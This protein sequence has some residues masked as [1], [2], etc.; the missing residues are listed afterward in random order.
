MKMENHQKGKR[1]EGLNDDHSVNLNE[2]L[3]TLVR[4]AVRDELK[5]TKEKPKEEIPASNH[6]E[7][8]FMTRKEVMALLKRCDSTMTKWAKRGYLKPCYVGGKYLYRKSDVMK[9]VGK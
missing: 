8:E 4:R 1:T 2:T 3:Y 5:E 9:L 6:D 7:H